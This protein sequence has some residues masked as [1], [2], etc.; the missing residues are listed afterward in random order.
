MCLTNSISI[1]F[2]E[3]TWKNTRNQAVSATTEKEFNKCVYISIL[4]QR[5]NTFIPFDTISLCIPS[6][7]RM[8]YM[9]EESERGQTGYP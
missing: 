1:P 8:S 3:S 4:I 2:D 9:T 5:K 6:Y 7:S